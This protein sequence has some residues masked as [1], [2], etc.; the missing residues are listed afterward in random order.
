M[1]NLIK[2]SP[3]PT[4]AK[5]SLITNYSL[6]AVQA[7]AILDMRLQRLTG[8]EREKI[9]K[10]YEEIIETIKDLEDILAKEERVNEIIK[11]E[12][13]G[14]LERYGDERKTEIVTDANEIQVIDLIKEEEVI[15]TITRKGYIKR[16]AADTYRSQKRGG[17][18]VKGAAMNEDFYTKIFT[19]NTHDD[20]YIFVN[21]GKIYSKKVYELPEGTRMSRGRNVINLIQLASGESVKE[22]IPI[23]KEMSFEG[24]YIII[25][26]ERGLIKKSRLTDYKRIKPSGLRAIKIIQGDN[27][28]TV[29]ITDGNQDILLCS[30]SGRAVRFNEE[31]CRPIGRVS[32]G[33]KGITLGIH[34]KLIAMEI[35]SDGDDILSVTENGRGKRTKA[36]EY[37]RKSR[38]GKGVIAMKITDKNGDI[39]DMK[40]VREGNDLMIVTDKG[41]VIRTRV[42]E[43]SLQGRSAQG[44]RVM[45]LRRGEKIVSVESV[46]E[47]PE[48]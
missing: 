20:I 12:F 21:N 5:S 26:T 34:E 1:V 39:I 28:R 6:S 7:Q 27:V 11:D 19:A 35:I 23:S 42:S 44:V 43:I 31:G 29:R 25:A 37:P 8:L 24:K 46:A 18:G 38:G 3:N 47:V 15:V 17:T 14:I 30:S 22:I 32:Q 4:E 45:R 40:P 36:I 33:V 9:I 41:Q 2:T 48:D 16:M 10:D 13:N